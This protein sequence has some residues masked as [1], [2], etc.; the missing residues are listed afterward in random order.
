MNPFLKAL[1]DA[2]VKTVFGI[3]GKRIL[4]MYDLLLDSNIK[5]ILT[6]HEQGAVHACDGYARVSGSPGTCIATAGPGALNLTMGVANAKK[7]NIPVVAITGVDDVSTNLF[8]NI[9]KKSVILENNVYETVLSCYEFSLKDCPGPVHIAVPEDVLK[10]K[11]DVKRRKF[12]VSR[13]K[14]DENLIRKLAE[15]I[16]NSSNPMIL[17]GSGILWS[18]ACKELV[19]LAESISIPV[20]TSMMAR[21]VIPEDH[22]LSLGVMG[23]RGNKKANEMLKET[24]LLIIIGCSASPLTIDLEDI[25]AEVVRIDVKK[26][27]SRVLADME[28]IGDAKLVLLGLLKY[29]INKKIGIKKD[30]E[31]LEGHK[32]FTSKSIC[33]TVH[34]TLGKKGITVYDI[35]SFTVWGCM[36]SKVYR[37][38]SFIV[39]GNFTPMGFSVPA[40]IGVQIAMPHELV[41]SIVGDG[42]FM[43]S[44]SELATIKQYEIPIKIVLIN[45]LSL[46]LIGQFQERIYG[47]TTSINLRNPD[48]TKLAN[49]YGINGERVDDIPSLNEVLNETIRI[50]EPFL[51]E[52][53]V[54]EEEQIPDLI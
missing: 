19:K 13:R 3:P 44:S 43:M 15:R 34:D 28:I 1:E 36:L 29:D 30:K 2:N 41:V 39:P 22:P 6:R 33:K 21:G 11:E 10:K 5:N 40:S 27:S 32:G 45:N 14:P 31:D 49:S 48:F 35:G 54:R 8:R 37:P 52:C 47:R 26:N 7:D 23:K 9:T 4:E 25:D 17:A 12:H 46:E 24:D 38:R 18:N 20:A 16:E 51:I 42:G 53:I 50:R